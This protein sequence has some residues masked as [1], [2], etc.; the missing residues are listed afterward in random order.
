M[1]IQEIKTVIMKELPHIMQT[2]EEIRR[3][4]VSIGRKQ[5]A[6][7][8]DSARRFDRMMDELAEQRRQSDIRFEKSEQRWKAARDELAEQRRQSDIRWEAQRRESQQRWE[9]NEQ[10]WEAQRKESQQRWEKNEQRWEAG[11][12]KSEQRWEELRQEFAAEMKRLDHSYKSTIGALGA[13]WGMRSEASFRNGL[14]GILQESFGVNVINV[15]EFDDEGMVFGRPDQ[16]ELDIIIRDGELIICEIKS[17]VDKP[18]MYIFERKVRFYE[19][20]HGKKADRMIVIS[21]MVHERAKA[22]ARELGIAVY[23]YADDVEG[24]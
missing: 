20:R 19:K 1:N 4:I 24:L 8:D 14:R 3:F 21:P 2:D 13:R 23:S 22:V 15:N 11:L 17:S 6:D 16:V 9:K 10:R 7:K 5:F 18:R 12:K